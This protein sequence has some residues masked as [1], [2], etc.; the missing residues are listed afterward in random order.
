[1]RSPATPPSR[2]RRSWRPIAAGFV[3]TGAVIAAGGCASQGGIGKALNQSLEKI[4]LKAPAPQQ[5]TEK[6]I[7]L[8]LYAGDNLNAGSSKRALALV[9]KVYQLRSARR[10]EQA[11][12]DAFLDETREQSVLGDDLVTVSEILLQPG[13]RHEVLEKVAA[14]GSHLGVVA[15]FL[16]PA[17]SRW[18]FVFD[19]G[20]AGADGITVGFHACAMTTTSPALVTALASEPHSLSGVNCAGS[21]R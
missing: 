16:S 7:P 8:R 9:V 21:P 5:P 4:G 11:P 6:S 12:F 15:L 19:A 3:L 14:E 18:R 20:K 17:S 2:H 10:F 1:M 13:Q